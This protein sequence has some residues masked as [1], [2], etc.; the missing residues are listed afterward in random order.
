MSLDD[1]D[2]A[3]LLD[4]DS[5]TSLPATSTPGSS[6]ARAS[7]HSDVDSMPSLE[8]VP[9]LTVTSADSGNS[10]DE[11]SESDHKQDAVIE[12]FENGDCKFISNVLYSSNY[13]K[14]P[15]RCELW[16]SPG[17]QGSPDLNGLE[18]INVFITYL[19]IHLNNYYIFMS[20]VF[21]GERS[22]NVLVNNFNVE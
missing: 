21:P 12:K 1:K 3:R 10:T 13:R 22:Q 7:D 6:P 19:F 14:L 5:D 9:G 20:Y 18:L 4:G 8:S 11:S 16:L 2:L 15:S 17:P